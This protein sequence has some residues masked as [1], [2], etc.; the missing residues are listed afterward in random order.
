MSFLNPL[1]A[2]IAAGIALPL[3]VALYFLKLK[4][5]PLKVPSTLL[6]KRAVQDLQV[7]APFQRIR[8]SLLLWVQL[9]LLALLLIVWARPARQA[10]VTTGDRVVLVI[11]R[12]ASMNAADGPGGTTR[13]EQAKAAA[14][15][16]VDGLS[17]SAGAMVV[18]FAQRAATVQAFTSD[19]A[20][21]RR[22][23]A[24]IEP[25][26][27]RSRLAPALAVAEQLVAAGGGADGDAA[28]GVY[29][30]SDGQVHR[31]GAEEPAL[32]GAELSFVRV[33]RPDTANVGLVQCSARRDPNDPGAV[34]V[35]AA[36]SNSGAE[37]AALNL[38]LTRDGRVE[39]ARAVTVPAAG[40]GAAGAVG[41]T[42]VTF[43]LRLI[44]GAEVEV[45]HDRSDALAADD[46]ARLVV[47][48]ARRLRVLLVS[49][50]GP[51]RVY[52][53]EALAAA[54]ALEVRPVEP[55]V[56]E[57]MDP[58]AL[59]DGG[60]AGGQERGFD[61]VVFDR[62]APAAEPR[63]ASLSFGAAPPV[64]G[65][66][67]VPAP[68]DAEGGDGGLQRVLTWKR[69]HPLMSYVVLDDVAL[70][71][72]GR[73]VVPPAATV[74]AVGINGPL[75]AEVRGATGLR[76]VAVGFDVL[77]SRWPHHWSFQ[78]F[79]VNALEVLA[80]SEQV[81]AGQAALAYRTGE[82]AAVPAVGGGRDGEGGVLRYAGSG[83]A[84]GTA[85]SGAVRQGR[86]LLSAFERAGRYLADDPATRAPYDRLAV[87]LL[88]GLESDLRAAETL[89]VASGAPVASAAVG[90]LIRQEVWPWFAWA[91]LVV[92]LAEWW[93]Y[94]RRMRV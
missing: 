46:R 28:L 51:S 4:R 73:L 64:A 80:L 37:P 83:A 10:A 41:E 78:V 33:G 75:M 86:A 69:E 57:A 70:R 29:V 36:L 25:T 35:F 32:P 3:L 55:R 22:A 27:Q 16:L 90:A 45:F 85:V 8:N 9:L 50:G 20:L 7:N 2:L 52:L 89:D 39:Q 34:R 72:P 53:Q 87:N 88:D 49:P 61:V 94:T 24:D 5:K 77:E 23:I 54:G 44:G 65:L 71:R 40:G 68:A 91:A 82:S 26:D 11:D 63:V 67:V 60:A 81:G 31:D 79:M 30:F 74:L 58:A 93:L 12:S 21:L 76:H 42:G 43:E 84:E 48:P 59:R 1:G 6:W 15:E 18:T 92:L 19:K 14:L 66:E 56:F 13:L 47:L 38:T 62:Y 17:G